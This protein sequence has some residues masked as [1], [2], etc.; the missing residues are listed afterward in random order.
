V[1]EGG[2]EGL[3]EGGEEGRKVGSGSQGKKGSEGR[4]EGRNLLFEV[5]AS[6][7]WALKSARCGRSGGGGP[8]F[9]SASTLPTS[10]LPS[11]RWPSPSPTHEPPRCQQQAHQPRHALPPSPS[12]QHGIVVPKSDGIR[13]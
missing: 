3:T 6:S 1:K 2:E 7:A 12:W 10:R 8:R 9:S 5:A 13:E 11:S 4:K